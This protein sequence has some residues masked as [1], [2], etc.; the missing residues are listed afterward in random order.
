MKRD[1]RSGAEQRLLKMA[2][3]PEK[4]SCISCSGTFYRSVI[5]G[6]RSSAFPPYTHTY[7]PIYIFNRYMSKE[8]AAMEKEKKN[9]LSSPV[10][11]TAMSRLD[12]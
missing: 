9:K 6:M 1:G 8:I 4:S 11:Y 2:S 7:T 12:T 3:I 5:T 10:F